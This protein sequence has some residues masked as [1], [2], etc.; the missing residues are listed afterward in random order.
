MMDANGGFPRELKRTKPYGY[1]LFQLD[2]IVMVAKVLSTP[3]DNLFAYTTPDGRN[4]RQALAFMYPFVQ[5]KAQWLARPGTQPDVMYWENCPV[6][7]CAWLY[8]GEAYGE[9]KYLE[10]WQR[11]NANP[12]VM[13]VLRNLPIRQ[14][15]LWE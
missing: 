15:V 3:E 8:G 4:L 11:L 1:S 12:K 14:P 2:Q 7:S 9:Q 10:L 6:R 5:D 13:E